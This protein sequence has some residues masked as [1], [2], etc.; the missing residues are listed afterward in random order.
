MIHFVYSF[1]S[2]DPRPLTPASVTSGHIDM[3]AWDKVAY[4]ITSK[5]P[6]W[7]LGTRETRVKLLAHQKDEVSFA[8]FV[9]FIFSEIY[10]FVF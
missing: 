6:S 4:G 1:Y 5:L 2:Q 9:L 10:C 7:K 8:I 3:E